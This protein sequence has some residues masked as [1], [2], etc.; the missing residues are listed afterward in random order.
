VGFDGYNLREQSYGDVVE[1]VEKAL[2][3][4]VDRS[5]VAYGTQG[6]TVG[7]P[8]SRGT[9]VHLAWRVPDRAGPG[10][11][12]VELASAIA[13]VGKPRL[14]RSYRWLDEARQV[15]WRAD[16]TDRIESPA[17]DG[18]GV[19]TSVPELPV[20]W[21]VHLG[22]SLSSL[23]KHETSRVTM[24]QDHL[25]KRINQVFGDRGLDTTI[26]DWTTVHG[27]LHWGNVTAPA[28]FILDWESWGLGPRGYDA[29]TLWGHSLLVPEVADRVRQQFVDD[30]GS[31][32][33]LLA[34]LLL[35]SNAIR[36]GRNKPTPGP[37]CEPATRE[38]ERLI[39]ALTS[40]PAR[41]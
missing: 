17:V 4:T 6:A 8:T 19:I 12:G 2:G 5:R 37:L 29:A 32:S 9:W 22:A 21:W 28:C 41:L 13:G 34:Q 25:T 15:V 20:G 23:S 7:F 1:V 39:S 36:L 14:F 35:V 31:R 26:T 27:D 38:A 18:T 10:W 11:T 30:L 24:A 3:V 40:E 16:E 33:G